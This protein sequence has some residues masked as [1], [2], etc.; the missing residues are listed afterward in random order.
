MADTPVTYVNQSSAEYIAYKLLEI[1][2]SNENKVLYLNNS[3]TADR[4]WLLDTYAECLTAVRG[5]R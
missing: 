4:K 2:A 1:I 3:A 5:L